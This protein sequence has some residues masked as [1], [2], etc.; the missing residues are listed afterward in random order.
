M[1]VF[2]DLV[3]RTD[4]IF[5]YLIHSFTFVNVHFVFHQYSFSVQGYTCVF[6]SFWK[7]LRS[8]KLLS[9][10]SL[11][12]ILMT[13]NRLISFEDFFLFFHSSA[14]SWWE[15]VHRYFQLKTLSNTTEINNYN[16]EWA[17]GLRGQFYQHFTSSFY[18]RRSQK[19]KK[20]VKS[21]VSF[22]AFGTYPHKICS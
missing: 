2:S 18:T 8:C 5:I 11:L 17:V 3:I 15:W 7:L 22:W 16:I 6:Y 1:T 10:S 12:H 21:S 20:T 14:P 9:I 19:C 4:A 13:K